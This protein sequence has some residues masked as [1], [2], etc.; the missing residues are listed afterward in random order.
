MRVLV[1]ALVHPRDADDVINPLSSMSMRE[2]RSSAVVLTGF[3]PS[4]S[5]AEWFES[6][7]IRIVHY[8]HFERVADELDLPPRTRGAIYS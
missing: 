6:K 1:G 4:R 5:F 3:T 8:S 7:R 2:P